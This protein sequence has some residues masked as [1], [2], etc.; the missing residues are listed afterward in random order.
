MSIS[1]SGS[2]PDT[3]QSFEM[4]INCTGVQKGNVT[5]ITELMFHLQSKPTSKITITRLKKCL[6]GRF[7]GTSFK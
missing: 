6:K 7:I 2:V 3:M 1:R 5:F 4:Y